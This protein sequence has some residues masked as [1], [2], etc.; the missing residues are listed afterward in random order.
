MTD[1][2]SFL[3]DPAHWAWSDPTSFPHRIL[4]HL[5][6]SGLALVLAFLVAFPLGV[7]IGHTRKGS[8]LVISL[9]NAGR[10]LPTIGVLLL[11]VVMVGIGLTPALVALVVLAVPPMLTA[12]YA[13]VAGVNPTVVDAARGIGLTEVQIATRVEVPNSLPIVIGGVRNAALQVISTATIVAYVGEGGLGRFLF[14]GIALQEYDQ[15]A[16]G[17]VV[18]ALLAVVVDLL[19]TGVQR[20]LVSPGLVSSAPRRPVLKVTRQP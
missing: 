1:M 7:L 18:L 3:T 13:G 11:V 2:F 19:L 4:E 17:G 5:W 12:T 20:L 15:A 16:A 10:S 9:G 8:F 14:D 6:Y